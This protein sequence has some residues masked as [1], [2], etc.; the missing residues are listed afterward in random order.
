MQA[1]VEP[2][3]C[4]RL[5][6]DDSAS[7]DVVRYFEIAEQRS[8]PV[9]DVAVD[10]MTTGL[11]V[12][13]CTYKR[14]ES[15]ARLIPSFA[16]QRLKPCRFIVIDAS[17]DDATE[18]VFRS[19][20]DTEKLACC[21]QYFR[22]SGGLKGLTRQ[23]NFGLRWVDTDL[24]AFFDDDVLLDPECLGEMERVHRAKGAEVVG[25]GAYIENG[26]TPP[27]RL[28]RVRRLL[29]IVPNL[30]PGSYTRSGMSVPWSFLPPT[31]QVVEGEWLIGCSM[32][33]R[34]SVAREFGFREAFPGYAQG[35]DLDFSRRV[36]SRGKLVLAGAARLQ[37]FHDQSGRPNFYK[38]GYMAIY[39]RFQIHRQG[40]DD[41]TWL[42]VAW[43]VYAWTLDSLMIARRFFRP[44][45]TLGTFQEYA[46]RAKAAFD[47]ITQSVTGRTSSSR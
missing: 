47:L 17:P 12:V 16:G 31:N 4:P 45:M 9:A 15:M 30:A 41:R 7:R 27:T 2:G 42:D 10:R 29:R 20:P 36:R 3:T 40:L 39:N 37:H 38:L 22:V 14:A 35:E 33:W 25:V 18:R 6:Q 1:I 44:R 26:Y 24:V 23:R 13:I 34:T 43:F 5:G 32:M 8:E 28:W 11:S 21:F 19:S 46:G